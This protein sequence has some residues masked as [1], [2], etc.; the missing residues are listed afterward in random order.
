[1][2]KVFEDDAISKVVA[3]PTGCGKTNV[4]ELCMLRLFSR[5]LA[6]DG[7]SLSKPGSMKVIY[8]APTRSLVQ[9]R[10]KEMLFPF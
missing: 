4:M 7:M 5:N 1:M 6:A 3:A 2:Q 8:I 10:V 9:E